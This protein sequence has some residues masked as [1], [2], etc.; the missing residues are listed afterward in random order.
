MGAVSQP[1]GRQRT[2]AANPIDLQRLPEPRQEA[3]PT[4]GTNLGQKSHFSLRFR[5]NPSPT[6]H[7]TPDPA[8]ADQYARW[9][10]AAEGARTERKEVGSGQLTIRWL[11]RR[12]YPQATAFV[13]LVGLNFCRSFFFALARVAVYLRSNRA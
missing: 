2:L 1:E 9:A 7:P 12:Q 11:R 13:P 10:R 5:A 8:K 4:L 6:I 3:L